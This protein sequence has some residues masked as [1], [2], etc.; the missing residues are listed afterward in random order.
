[1]PEARAEE[2]WIKMRK[3]KLSMRL[4]RIFNKP[5]IAMKTIYPII[6]QAF[7]IAVPTMRYLMP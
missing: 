5:T 4:R 6:A 3:G 7:P 2:S 1:M